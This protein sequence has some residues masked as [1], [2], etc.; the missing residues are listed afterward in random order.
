[1]NILVTILL[2]GIVISG[3]II[4]MHVD[5]GV[6]KSVV[7]SRFIIAAVL[8]CIA[9]LPAVSGFFPKLLKLIAISSSSTLMFIS[10]RG[11]DMPSDQVI[12]APAFWAWIL[13]FITG[14]LVALLA[15]P[16][17][18]PLQHLHFIK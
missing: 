9:Y 2:L 16:I 8:F 10:L 13:S 15:T 4:D 1:M 11:T 5:T 17:P 14:V 3:Y 12:K 6:S 18:T 7:N